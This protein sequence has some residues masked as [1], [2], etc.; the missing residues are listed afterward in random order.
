[1][2]HFAELRWL[3]L[4]LPLV[5]LAVLFARVHL[6][7]LAWVEAR[8]APRRRHRLSR[9]GRGSLAVHLMLLL[10]CALLLLAALARPQLPRGG[11][12]KVRDGRVLL[13]LDASASMYAEDAPPILRGQDRESL[14]RFAAAQQIALLVVDR[15]PS[16]FLLATYSGQATVHLP[17]TTDR[18]QVRRALAAAETHTPY[19]HS[20]SSLAGALDL[21][22]ELVGEGAADLQVVLLGDGELPFEE[23]YEAPLEALAARGVPVHAVTIGSDDGEGRVIYSMEDVV[24]GKPPEQRRKLTEFVTRREDRHFRRIAEATGGIFT[25]AQDAGAVDTLVG[26]LEDH[27]FDPRR[28]L[29]GGRELGVGA[30]E[31]FAATT[32]G[33][34]Q[35]GVPRD[36]AHWFLGAFLLCFLAERLWWRRP[37][38]AEEMDGEGFD[39]SRIGS[40][41]RGRRF[42]AL[43]P[44]L[45]PA[46][47]VLG[48][49]TPSQ[50]AH[51]ENELGILQDAVGAG[52]AARAHF[53]RSAAFG[54][55]AEIPLFNLARSWTADGE[56][57]EA[58]RIYQEVLLQAPDLWRAHYGDGVTLFRWGVEEE[59][60]AGC[61]LE[62]TVELWRAAEERFAATS[63]GTSDRAL[64]AD[65]EANLRF[66]RERLR[67]LEELMANPP[68]ECGAAAQSSEGGGEDEQ[69]SP[70]PENGSEASS[71]ERDGSPPPRTSENGDSAP[72]GTLGGNDLE[73]I[74]QAL[75][76]V[77][78]SGQEEGKFHRRTRAEQFSEESWRQPTEEVWW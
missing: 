25:I 11:E 40:P 43:L 71:A 34:P 2:I 42:V 15:V 56:H 33:A 69:E 26:A 22:L 20:G 74:R 30:A 68:P 75:E 14:S 16:R 66:V 4:L 5:L 28:E 54:H 18:P 6:Q 38:D 32:D 67:E 45:L 51:Q 60:P 23:E 65:A 10:L 36:L 52:E 7:A 24:A 70:P 41:R 73:E 19:Q 77:E 57:S 58:H 61:R 35:A 48:C 31:T 3:L 12:A 53:R 13:L 39:L 27:R 17:A 55:R 76:R 63:E 21:I 29:Q 47:L 64:G 9:H 1:M 46:L 8:V 72:D 59:D 49:G 78:A 44:V 50:R 62:A 37:P